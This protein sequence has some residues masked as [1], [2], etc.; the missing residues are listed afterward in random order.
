[1]LVVDP[2]ERVRRMVVAIVVIAEDE[3]EQVE[4]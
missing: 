4:D 2:A 3:G 1:M